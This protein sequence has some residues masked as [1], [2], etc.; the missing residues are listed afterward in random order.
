MKTKLDLTRFFDDKKFARAVNFTKE[1]FSLFNKFEW[2]VL[3][4]NGLKQINGGYSKVTIYDAEYEPDGK[5]G[6]ICYFLCEVEC[7]EQDTGDGRSNC[8]K[9]RVQFNRNTKKFEEK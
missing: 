6:E 8:D 9:W 2:A 5:N 1:E 7:G 3:C 4:N